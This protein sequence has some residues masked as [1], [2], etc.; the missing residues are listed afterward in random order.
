MSQ[1]TRLVAGC[2]AVAALLLPALWNG[3]PLVY[4]DTGGYLE[5]PFLGTLEL[6]RSALYGV[7][8][9][10]GMKLDFW[11]NVSLQAAL[12]AWLLFLTLRAHGWGQRPWLAFGVAALLAVSTSLPLYVSQLMPDMMFPAGV[13]ALHLLAFRTD[14]LGRGERFCLAAVIALAIAAHM[15]NFALM[16]ALMT[17]FFITARI[18][19]TGWPKVRLAWTSA[20][21]ACGVALC[22]L[23][24]AAITG[25]FAFTPGGTN[26]LF[27]RLIEDGIVTRYLDAQC[28][29]PNLRICEYRG[30]ISEGL[31]D[32][33]WKNGTPFW[34]LGGWQ[35]HSGEE[36]RIIIATLT[37]YPLAHLTTA[38]AAAAGQFVA[39]ASEFVTSPWDNARTLDTLVQREPRLRPRLMTA[40]QQRGS[41]DISALNAIHVPV[42]ALSLIGIA[43][44]ILFGARFAVTPHARALCL[45]VFLALFIN[46]AVSG[47]FSHPSDRYQSRL[48]S[49]APFALM[50]A[51]L[52]RRRAA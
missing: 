31:D 47:I 51:L 3:F 18:G 2:A 34:K 24:N 41:L 12:I 6:G 16:A 21:V 29:D 7:Y 27:Q 40:R 1:A 13:L 22:P 45:S 42:A 37:R 28:P 52:S 48:V 46:A 43:G 15:A 44:M 35:G 20:A 30:E 23:S 17:A 8:L 14:A 32:W 4:P 9:A 38:A 11:P 33:L 5:R 26:F 19:P 10:A 49:L 39:F 25:Q 50:V 36:R